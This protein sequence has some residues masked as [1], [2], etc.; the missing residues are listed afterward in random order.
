[1]KEKCTKVL[2]S[3]VKLCI[4]M[5]YTLIIVFIIDK[6]I[7]DSFYNCFFV[8]GVIYIIIGYI[9]LTKNSKRILPIIIT[10]I[11]TRN[12]SINLESN[13]RINIEVDKAERDLDL[14]RIN[15][16]IKPTNK[17][18]DLFFR[19]SGIELIVY[20]VLLIATLFIKYQ[21]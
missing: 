7:E 3:I 21:V 14:E 4:Y 5:I 19:R 18:V 11:G 15:N 2:I 17:F 8:F 10:P 20:G 13:M 1:M 6:V 12:S 9:K 16:N